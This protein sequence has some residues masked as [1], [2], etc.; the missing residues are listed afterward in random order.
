MG[1]FVKIKEPKWGLALCDATQGS[2]GGQTWLV[3]SIKDLETCRKIIKD[4]RLNPNDFQACFVC[5]CG[6]SVCVCVSVCVLEGGKG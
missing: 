2:K 4:K 6:Q 1:A 3:H 5:V